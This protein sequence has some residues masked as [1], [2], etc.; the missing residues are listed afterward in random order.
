WDGA[1][2][3]IEKTRMRIRSLVFRSRV[4]AELDDELRFHLEQQVREHLDNGV[5]SQDVY[6][7]ALRDLG[8]PERIKEECRE[9]RKVRHIENLEQDLR[10][11]FRILIRKPGFAVVAMLTLGLGVGANTALFSLVNG[12]VLQP[13]PYYDPDRLVR[14][15]EYYPKG[16]Y[17]LLNDESQT[18]DVAACAAGLELNLAQPG[19]APV[20]LTGA[21]VSASFFPMLGVKAELGRAFHEGE[22]AP[23]SNRVVILSHSLWQNLF[24]GAPDIIGRRITIEGSSR[25]VIGVMPPDFNFASNRSSVWVPLNM[26]PRD[27][28][29]F[30][31]PEMPLFARLRPAASL[32][33]ARLELA[34]LMPR[35]IAAFPYHMPA[36]W[37]KDVTVIPLQQDLVGDMRSKLLILFGAV[38]IVLLIACANV[39]SLL[40]ARSAGRRQELAIRS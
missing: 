16:A 24:G 4:D 22:D 36:G 38:S 1:M 3:W 10:F 32:Q 35:V 20:R 5:P 31:G 30:W 28:S 34:Q 6:R 17:A 29:D 11:G 21:L 8:I 9:M 12:I 27:A 33:Q 2:R 18:M 23:G 40:M 15:T 13:L 37:N 19:S 25:E 7:L 14:L 26:E 39:A